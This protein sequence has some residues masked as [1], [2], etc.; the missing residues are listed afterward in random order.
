VNLTA[1]I[2]A[3]AAPNLGIGHVARC[4]SLASVLADKG[5]DITFASRPGTRESAPMLDDAAVE[6]FE[7]KPD[8]DDET[9][10]MKKQ[11]PAGIDLLVVDSY[12]LDANFETGCRK[13]SQQIVTID[14]LADRRHDCDILVDSSP[15]RQAK[16]YDG[17]IPN[18]CNLMLGSSHALLRPG[19]ARLRPSTIHRRGKPGP[20]DRLLINFGGT[21]AWNLTPLVIEAVALSKLK[22]GADIMLGSG[23]VNQED[24]KA[25]IAQYLPGARLHVGHSRPEQLMANADLAI[26][27]GG[28][29]AWERCALGLAS[30]VI[31]TSGNQDSIISALDEAG[32]IWPAGHRRDLT[33][34]KLSFLLNSVIEDDAARSAVSSRAAQLCDGL[35]ARRVAQGILAPL[36]KD[37]LRIS[38]R[39]ITH[40]DGDL[41]LIW[42]QDPEI[43]R[44]FRDSNAPSAEEHLNWMTSRLADPGCCFNM[45]CHGGEAAGIIRLDMIEATGPGTDFEVSILVGPRKQELGIGAAALGLARDLLPEADFHA[46]VLER[47]IASHTLFARAGYQEITPGH[48][49]HPA[50][51][52]P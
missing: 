29:T 10:Q 24:V 43:R 27:A 15:A 22:C 23:A 25:A 36:A 8:S 31:Q 49:V 35:G 30:I 50:R 11:W 42:Q 33:V 5:Y 12:E 46:E 17:R 48:Y 34:Q 21:D 51:Q 4:L 9:G 7:F 28:G 45:I 41:L 6:I 38:L 26:G 20:I 44:F 14:D 16:D 19:F 32:A 39:P 47:N 2:R 52:I 1:V 13:W 40:A 37:Q 3:D 18:D